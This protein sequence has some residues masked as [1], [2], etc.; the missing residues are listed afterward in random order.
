MIGAITGMNIH[1]NARLTPQGRLLLVRRVD[2]LGWRM[3][4]AAGVAGISQRQGYRWL[5]RTAAAARRHWL[6]AARRPGAAR[7]A[8]APSASPKSRDCGGSE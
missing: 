5:A 7:I 8:S 1:Q 6:T 4:E 3:A 2:E